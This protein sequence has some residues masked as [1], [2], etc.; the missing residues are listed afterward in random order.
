MCLQ[1]TPLNPNIEYRNKFKIR[2][3]QCSKQRLR[4]QYRASTFRSF[5][6]W[7]FGFVSNFVLR[8]SNFLLEMPG[9]GRRYPQIR[10]FDVVILPLLLRTAQPPV[11]DGGIGRRR[12]PF[13]QEVDRGFPALAG[14]PTRGQ[15]SHQQPSWP[16]SGVR[17]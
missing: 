3:S 14:D 17:L 16:P 10:T 2:I 4:N 6:F 13:V 11:S 15:K 1:E 5:E 7:S 8:I 12:F 9:K